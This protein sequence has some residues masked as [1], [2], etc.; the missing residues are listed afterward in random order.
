MNPLPNRPLLSTNPTLPLTLPNVPTFDQ[1]AYNGRPRKIV[2][3]V[4]KDF[5]SLNGMMA[6]PQTAPPS[7]SQVPLLERDSRPNPSQGI[8]L[9]PSPAQQ[10]QPNPAIANLQTQQNQQSQSQPA[11]LVEQQQQPPLSI[12]TIQQQFQAESTSDLKDASAEAT[13][14]QLQ[15]AIFRPGREWKEE[16]ERV[17]LEKASQQGGV[18]SGASAWDTAPKEEDEEA[19]EE[20]QDVEEEEETASTA[21]EEDGNLWRPRRTLRKYVCHAVVNA[22]KA[23]LCLLVILIRFELLLSIRKTWFGFWRG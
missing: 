1:I 14:P 23:L 12:Q 2:P 4:G 22:I 9:L 21:S 19:K 13:E 17:R 11:P 20:E 18:M 5:P 16:L 3:E 15:T 7:T 6:G 10:P 8:S